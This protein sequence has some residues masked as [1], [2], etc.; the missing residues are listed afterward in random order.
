MYVY[1]CVSLRVIMFLCLYVNTCIH[2]L[3][4]FCLLKDIVG[5]P[6]TRVLFVGKS[7]NKHTGGLET[8]A[9]TTEEDTS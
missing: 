1:K 8:S 3:L 2:A 6:L 7:P 5:K 9:Q 4:I